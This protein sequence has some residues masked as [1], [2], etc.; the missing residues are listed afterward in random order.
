[1]YSMSQFMAGKGTTDTIFMV[2]KLKE[3]YLAMN[4]VLTECLGR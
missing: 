3:K 2:C 4:I 1:M